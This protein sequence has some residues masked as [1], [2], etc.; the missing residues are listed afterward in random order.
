MLPSTCAECL[1]R[2]LGE[3]PN[4]LRHYGGAALL[5]RGGH[6]F[7][8]P[9]RSRPAASPSQPR[10]S[11]L[12]PPCAPHAPVQPQAPCYPAPASGGPFALRSPCAQTAAVGGLN[13][14]A[15]GMVPPGYGGTLQAEYSVSSRSIQD[16]V[17][18]GYAGYDVDALNPSLIDLQLQG[19]SIELKLFQK[20]HGIGPQTSASY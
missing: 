10:P 8:N 12:S 14:P 6:S 18:E 20:K 1:D 17:A 13:S 15:A 11:G 4:R 7:S 19:R 3:R 2:L 9:A 16:L 5:P